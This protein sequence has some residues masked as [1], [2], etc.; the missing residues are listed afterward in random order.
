MKERKKALTGIG[1]GILAALAL[2]FVFSIGFAA[3]RRG[4][5]FWERRNIFRD[6]VPPMTAR[7][8]VIGTIDSIGKDTLVVKDRTGALR[9]ITINGN[10]RIV[11]DARV[12][13]KFQDLKKG[14]MVI[15]LGMPGQQNS[16]IMARVIRVIGNPENNQAT[17]SALPSV[18]GSSNN[19]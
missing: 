11:E 10:T 4:F 15:V 6:F 14:E 17:P 9:T 19:L 13:I 8:G 16:E 1:I 5:P 18:P 3:G 2:L 7:Y 12:E